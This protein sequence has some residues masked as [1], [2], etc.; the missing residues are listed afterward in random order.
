LIC[1]IFFFVLSFS[2]LVQAFGGETI[3]ET[4]NE[5]EDN[6]AID[7]REIGFNVGR[8]IEPAHDRS[9]ELWFFF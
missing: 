2:I 8:W 9:R 7:L 1:F 3:W 5:T 4:K 6:V